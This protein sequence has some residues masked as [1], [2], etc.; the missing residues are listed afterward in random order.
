MTHGAVLVVEDDQPLK[1]ALAATLG[2]AGLAVL[3]ASNGEEALGKLE[4]AQVDLVISD[5]Q[6]APMDGFELLR[7]LGVRYPNLPVLLMTA[8]GSIDKAVEAMKY[9]AADYLVKPFE[10]AELQARVSRFLKPDVPHKD[11]IAADPLSRELFATA[12]RV[13][14]TSATVLLGG[15]SGSG[16]EVIARFIHNASPRANGPLVALNCAAIPENMLEA[17]LFGH[18]KGAFTGATG[19]SDGKFVQA[20]G[21]T[22]LLD[23]ISE[24]DLALQAKLLRVLQEREVEP[25]GG[26]APL[27]IDVRVVATTNRDLAKE[28]AEGRFREDL[29]YRLNVFPLRVPPLRERPLDVLPLAQH[30]VA[31]HQPIDPPAFSAHARAE[32]FTHRWP[33]NV[34]ELENAV[35]R[36]LVLLNGPT[37]ETQHLRLEPVEYRQTDVGDPPAIAIDELNHEL[38]GELKAQETR[39]IIEAL[40]FSGG[41]RGAAAE[42]LGISPRTLRYKLARMRAAGVAV[43]C[44]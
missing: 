30:F 8:Y 5:V 7:A 21:G 39:L 43:P 31:R 25:I 12:E 14:A 3:E 36:A 15:E 34:R 11:F 19:R 33:G 10:A 28:V 20:N 32:M 23:E 26:R 40:E 1:A 37:I 42:R 4:A 27:P 17:L 24:M 38:V 2:G 41:R 16:K 6:M 22:L 18:E 13:A 9:G 44:R 29:F 35:E